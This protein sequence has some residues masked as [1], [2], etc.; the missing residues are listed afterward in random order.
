MHILS[1][2]NQNQGSVMT[3]KEDGRECSL[4]AYPILLLPPN[5]KVEDVLDT[6]SAFHQKY[7]QPFFSGSVSYEDSNGNRYVEPFQIDLTF[8]KKRLSLKESSILVE[9]DRLNETLELIAEHRNRKMD[10][11]G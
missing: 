3:D 6:S 9:L 7:P 11:S 1:W 5:E 2:L 4:T 8:L 10:D